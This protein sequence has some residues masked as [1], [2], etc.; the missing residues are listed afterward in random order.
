MNITFIIHTYKRPGCV[1]RLIESIKDFYPDIPV[2]VYDDTEFDRGLSWG[3]NHLVSQVKTPYFLLLDDDFVFTADTKIERLYEKA[4]QGYDVVAGALLENSILH[5]EGRYELE[6]GVLRYIPTTEEP[7]D[8]VLNF[9]VGRTEKFKECKWDEELKL[10]EH[11]AFFFAHKGKL[12]IAYD[13]SAIAKHL[14]EKP[15]GY[16]EDRKRGGHYF[17]YWMKKMGINEVINTKGE[18]LRVSKVKK[19]YVPPVFKL[20]EVKS[21]LICSPEQHTKTGQPMY[22]KNLKKGLEELGIKVDCR[23]YNSSLSSYIG[24]Y[25]IVVINDYAPRFLD[26]TS[27][28]MIVNICH[29]KNDCDKPIIDDRIDYYL[30]PREQISE[31]WQKHYKID[32]EILPIPID[33]KKWQVPR[34]K[35]DKYTIIMPGTF[36]PQRKAMILNLI[37]RTKN[38]KNNKVILIGKDYMGIPYG[39][40]GDLLIHPE[41]DDIE[42]WMAK[43]DEVA[44]IHI[45]TTTLEAWA[46]GL[47]TSVYDEQGNWKYVEKPEDFNKHNYIEVARQLIKIAIQ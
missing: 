15:E 23:D 22:V 13:S 35:N 27:G 38:N 44:G 47:K 18:S 12:K 39:D 41:V 36:D 32:F 30:A 25:D 16:A 9:F 34:Q 11:T 10:G 8:Y 43:A 19:P 42:N 6:D 45:G 26:L 33:F 3:R 14:P 24:T 20:E 46:M 28:N 2:L 7:L 4:E 21:V 29:S 5:Y 40:K 31:H 1:K 37:E 17:R